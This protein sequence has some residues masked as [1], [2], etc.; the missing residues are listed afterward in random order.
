[1]QIPSS[2]TGTAMDRAS[3]GPPLRKEN[4]PKLLFRFV[5][6]LENNKYKEFDHYKTCETEVE[7]W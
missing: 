2:P 6:L 4:E 3:S 5:Y 7:A 1:M